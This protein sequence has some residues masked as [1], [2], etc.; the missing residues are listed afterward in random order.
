MSNEKR[1]KVL[2][3]GGSVA[4][5]TLANILEQ[6]GIDYLILEKYGQI[7]PDM[8]ASIGIFPNGFRILDQLGCYDSIKGL[9]EGADAFQ[10]LNM[11]NEHGQVI[12][13][14]KDAS[15]KFNERY[16]KY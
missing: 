15:Q 3:A 7:A 12:S 11:R 13:E 1:V 16:V 2:I 4:G 14:L 10:T 6:I 5:L 8:G 9:V